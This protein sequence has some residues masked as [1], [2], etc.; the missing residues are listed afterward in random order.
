MHE[1]EDVHEER[2]RTRT[3]HAVEAEEDEV[4]ASGD[5]PRIRAS[6]LGGPKRAS[7]ASTMVSTQSLSDID[8]VSRSRS[9]CSRWRTSAWKFSR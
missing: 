9:K 4:P 3:R 5:A 7:N 1:E 2:A 8:P 6:D